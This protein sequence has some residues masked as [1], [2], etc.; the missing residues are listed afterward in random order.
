MVVIKKGY[1]GCDCKDILLLPKGFAKGS[2]HFKYDF[3]KRKFGSAYSA[4][5]KCK[6]KTKA[7][8]KED[9]EKLEGISKITDPDGNIY[10]GEFFRGQFHGNGKN[11]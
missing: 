6:K 11:I 7:K 3:C 9:T 8:I 4:N 10:E 5:K 1:T 2:Y